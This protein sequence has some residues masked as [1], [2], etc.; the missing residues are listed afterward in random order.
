MPSITVGR[1]NSPRSSCIP[2]E[3]TG[4]RVGGLNQDVALVVL[5]GGPHAIPWTHA[6]QVNDALLRFIGAQ[7]P[8]I[9]G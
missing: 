8:A 3:K 1:E 5:E 9:A 7:V 2:F 4:K 6:Q